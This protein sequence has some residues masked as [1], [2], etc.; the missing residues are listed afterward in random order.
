MLIAIPAQVAIGDTLYPVNAEGEVVEVSAE[1]L[2]TKVL[3]VEGLPFGLS[4][5]ELN[6][7]QVEAVVLALEAEFERR[8]R[9]LHRLP[10]EL[11][12]VLGQLR[13]A[14]EYR[15]TLPDP[16]EAANEL[17]GAYR[18]TVE[19]MERRVETALADLGEA[20]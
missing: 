11:R 14:K 8:H 1:E 5:G 9:A 12:R 13:R 17:V 6:P 2:K 18:F 20:A 7:L 16:L 19:E 15:P 4:Y 10:Q 3:K